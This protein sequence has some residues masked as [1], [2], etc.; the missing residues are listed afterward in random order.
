MYLPFKGYEF[1]AKTFLAAAHLI[2]DEYL[3]DFTH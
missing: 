2:C 3:D 1:T